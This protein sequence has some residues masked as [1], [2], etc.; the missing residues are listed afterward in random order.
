MRLSAIICL[1]IIISC[2]SKKEENILA[3]VNGEKLYLSDIVA[4]IPSLDSGQD[5]MSFINQR[6][7]QWTREQIILAQAKK[8]I[9]SQETEKLIKDYRNQL[10]I[11]QYE[12]K[13]MSQNLDTIVR[14]DEIIS[15]IR[16]NNIDVDQGGP[17]VKAKFGK[18]RSNQ[19][20]LEKVDTLWQSKKWDKLKSYC[21]TFA[22]VCVLN[23]KWI[24]LTE[25]QQ[26]FPKEI[27][28]SD[29]LEKKGYHQKSGS[30]YEYFL[31]ITDFQKK[32][33]GISELDKQKIKKLILHARSKSFL[34][35]YKEKLYQ[36]SLNNQKIKFY[37]N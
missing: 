13:L 34:K 33:E 5:S 21:G 20:D 4:S 29:V 19:P 25:L 35:E 17:L 37:F 27:F 12:N 36:E 14:E 26:Y 18:F 28:N 1:L 11:T 9:E 31:S 7:E 22:E 15:Y 2:S 6:A 16:D 30:R 32:S 8:E 10:L 24:S 23:D 3:D